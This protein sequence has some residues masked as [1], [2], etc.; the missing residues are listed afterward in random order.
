MSRPGL[1]NRARGIFVMALKSS[2]PRIAIIGA[3]IIGLSIAFE[4][5]VRRGAAVTIHETRKPGR[6]ASWAA[7]GMIAPAFEAAA[8]PGV[9]P[10]LLDLCMAS[11]ALWPDF[12]REIATASGADVGLS[13]A[14]P[15]APARDPAPRAPP[16]AGAGRPPRRARRACRALPKC[17]PRGACRSRR[18]R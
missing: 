9:H 15:P 1:L 13:A 18:S 17:L 5:A 3:G 11:A 6:G 4:L 14:P 2:T 8:E 12:A 16:A 7:A 10:E